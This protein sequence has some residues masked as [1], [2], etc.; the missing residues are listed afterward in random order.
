[1]CKCASGKRRLPSRSKHGAAVLGRIACKHSTKA[2]N[3]ACGDQYGA[4]ESSLACLEA[5]IMEREHCTGDK[6]RC[7]SQG[8][9]AQLDV[10]RAPAQ[11]EEA[12]GAAGGAQDRG[13]L[14]NKSDGTGKDGVIENKMGDS[15]YA[16]AELE[17][18][19][20]ALQRNTA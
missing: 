11:L 9:M 4:T 20:Q 10:W 8:E 17:L 1:M 14:C 7:A 6:H 12:R 5:A 15:V 3:G 19:R 16:C 18:R 13:Q 2:V